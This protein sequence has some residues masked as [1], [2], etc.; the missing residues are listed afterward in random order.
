MRMPPR[1]AYMYVQ[2]VRRSCRMMMPYG[3]ICTVSALV[4]K[5][6]KR[7]DACAQCDACFECL[8][9]AGILDGR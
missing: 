5:R 6:G 2:S 9:K 4:E 7:H 3:C 8:R 1:S